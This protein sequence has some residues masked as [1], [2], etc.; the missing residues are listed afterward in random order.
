[1][2][3]TQYIGA[4]P[5]D[6]SEPL[7]A[8]I[9]RMD[10]IGCD[11]ATQRGAHDNWPCVW[12]QR[13]CEHP[14]ADFRYLSIVE[15]A[16]AEQRMNPDAYSKFWENWARYIL[17]EWRWHHDRQAL[18]AELD[19]R[20]GAG[21]VEAFLKD[22]ARRAEM[23]LDK[24][25]RQRFFTQW[26]GFVS[27]SMIRAAR[28]IAKQTIDQL[29]ALGPRPTKKQAVPIL[30]NYIESFNV[31][32]DPIDTISRDDICDVFYE[33]VRVTGLKGCDDLAERWRDF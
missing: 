29:I 20:N 13:W 12:W 18:V 6:L 19:E 10:S 30:R 2:A 17:Q 32:A 4:K 11:R 16:P 1:M 14:P 21:S 15:P 3:A 26:D 24:L 9:L 25:R 31:M 23:T 7:L 27:T 33:I 28:K 5:P 22:K 8:S